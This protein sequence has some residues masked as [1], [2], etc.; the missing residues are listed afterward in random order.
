M[1]KSSLLALYR[2]AAY[3]ATQGLRRNWP[4]LIGSIVLAILIIVI[5]NTFGSLGIAGGM[6]VG[7]AQVA[8]LSLHYSWLAATVEREKL[9]LRSLLGFDY[10]M[11]FTVISVAFV[12]FIIQ[13]VA[14]SLLQGIDKTFLLFLGLGLA[15]VFNAIPEVIIVERIESMPALGRAAEFTRDHALAWFLPLVF[16]LLPALMQSYDVVLISLASIDPLSPA[17]IVPLPIAALLGGTVT[18][19]LTLALSI[20]VANWYMLFRINLFKKLSR[21]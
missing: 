17:L 2:A 14:G 15:F 7:M 9:S 12:F 11:F 16:L 21:S 13:F 5:R 6:L 20:V 1:S 18:P 8:V 19:I 4:I 3:E 10:G